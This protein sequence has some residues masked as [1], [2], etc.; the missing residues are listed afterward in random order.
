MSNGSLRLRR[1]AF[2][3]PEKN[4]EMTFSNGVNVV[5]GASDTG[6]SFLAESIDFMLGGGELRD[7]PERVAYG[8]IH[9]DLDVTSGEKWR[10]LRG[11]TGGNFKL[12]NLVD[13]EAG[14]EVLKKD[15][16]HG[17]TDNLSGFLL[18]RIGLFGRRILKSKATGKTQS[19]SFRNL[20]KLAI[21][22]EGKI[23]QTGSPFW[24]GQFTLKTVELATIKLLLTGIDDSNV[25]E[26]IQAE[27]DRSK[28][29]EL[30]DELLADIQ[31][32]IASFGEKEADLKVQMTWLDI[33][34]GQRKASLNSTQAQLDV[35]L[36]KRRELLENRTAIQDR[37]DEIKDLLTRFDLLLKHYAID[38][39]RLTSIQESGVMFAHVESI[40]CPLCGAPPETQQ[41]HNRAT[42]LCFP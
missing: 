23:Q 42:R 6:N 15:H 30:I 39:E 3:G 25:V 31:Q 36:M 27:K 32:E 41:H 13:K 9:F 40:S 14:I 11:I 33:S 34:I 26:S 37:L 8:E 29:V 38:I 16:S 35:L 17:K 18:D 10:F 2:T 28:Q 7:I 20:A 22:Q 21:V 1:I 12:L 4:K 19:L 5:C 24:G